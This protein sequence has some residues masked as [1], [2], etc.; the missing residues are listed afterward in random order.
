[1]TAQKFP[2]S[3]VPDQANRATT[4]RYWPLWSYDPSTSIWDIDGNPEGHREQ[5]KF[6]G[7]FIDDFARH[8]GRFRS[9]F[10]SAGAPSPLLLA[11]EEENLRIWKLLQKQAG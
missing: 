1:M 5:A 3:L 4:T 11:Q 6:E 7:N 2:A 10:D 8:E 9:Q